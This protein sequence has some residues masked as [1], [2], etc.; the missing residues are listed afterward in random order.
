MK[1]I[2]LANEEISLFEEL[3][4]GK[5]TNMA[6]MTRFGLPVPEWFC[7]SAEA[8]RE[9]VQM[10][11]FQDLI[12]VRGDADLA[13]LS[14]QIE[15]LFVQAAL[16]PFLSS[17]LKETLEKTGLIDCEL[18]VRSSGLDEDSSK[19]SFAGQFSSYLFQR[20]LAQ[21]EISLRLCWASGFS[22]RALNYRLERGLQTDHIAVG[23]VVQKM[24][25]AEKA[26]VAFTRHPIRVLDRD[27]VLISSVWG[28]GEGLVSGELVADTYEYSREKKN[29]VKKEIAEKYQFLQRTS[30]GGVEKVN[31]QTSKR[32]TSSLSDL[33]V[34]A[35]GELCVRI[36]KYFERPQDCEFSFENNI[37]YLVQTRP[38][39]NIP[40]DMFFESSVNGQT[41]H[42]WDNS[43]IIES[44]SGV[45]TPLTFTFASRAY[46]QVYIQFCETMGVP[47][48]LVKSND[49][50][51]RNML[52]LVRGRIYYNLI[53]WYRLVLMLPGSSTN[54]GFMETMMGVQQQLKPELG[55][56]FEFA[57]NPPQYG[58]GA[59]LKLFIKTWRRFRKIDEIAEIF[60]REFN[61]AYL[62]A[63]QMDFNKIPLSELLEVYQSIEDRLLTKWR[64]P[65]IND[66]LC[67]IFF[68]TLKRITGKWVKP[69]A[70]EDLSSLQNDLLCGEGGVESTE[71]TK[72]LMRIAAHIFQNKSEAFCQWFISSNPEKVWEGLQSETE[73]RDVI[74]D[75]R[76]FL[77]TYGF[78]CVNE[79]KLEEPDLHDDPSFVIDSIAGYIRTK[80]YSIEEMEKREKAIRKKAESLVE[81]R[82]G[83]FK[84]LIFHWVLKHT[85]QA[86]KNRENLR[87]LRTKIFGVCRHIFRGMGLQ[88]SR[89][90]IIKESHDVFYLQ[91]DEL[92]GYI[93][94]RT[95]TQDLGA[96]VAI[97]KKEF[98]EYRHTPSPPDRFMSVGTVGLA[99]A[100]SE[101][102][103]EWDLIAKEADLRNDPNV[104][105]GTPCSPGVVEGVVR[106]VHNLKDA[107]GMNNEILVT[108]RT[109][110]GWVPL[111]PSCKGLL[112]E[113]GS[114]LS[115]S[116]V[117]AREMGIPTIVGI[118]GGL[119]NKLRTGQRI[120]M[121]ASKGEVRIL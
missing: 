16:P 104:L 36:E 98:A 6:K 67:M 70:G 112:V 47:V 54:K 24:V 106:V 107:C 52:G 57:N 81:E 90:G 8:F 38:I 79:L 117:V 60:F 45:T 83:Y 86:V 95:V 78:R 28:I 71:P 51:F 37:L 93:E 115:H 20:G 87:F 101:V 46:R 48:A 65:I 109:D 82:I 4:G 84:K 55:K 69:K 88:M 72:H 10:N 44:Y 50:I 97:R 21:I 58:F 89:L 17:E 85:R 66:Y 42:L 121:D 103:Q 15:E 43:N 92:L 113:R 114:L 111:Y 18:A 73:A 80:S 5:A 31:L 9:F 61:Q 32:S 53:N 49:A 110:P 14:K 1:R 25:K 7:V 75:L 40:P 41:T 23:V 118:R 105:I 19:H 100:F 74:K 30:Q 62:E 76:T 99:N 27:I 68:G 34:Q 120:R 56:L 116:A 64:A 59:K 108:A 12:K 35:V 29:I 77:D 96:V 63:R 26:G 91:L 39:T 13:T 22:E 94:G 2:L 119:M 3:G 102:L 11:E 33:E